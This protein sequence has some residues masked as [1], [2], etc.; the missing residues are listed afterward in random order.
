[1]NT[2]HGNAV[3]V[4]SRRQVAAIVALKRARR[5][6]VFIALRLTVATASAATV[7]SEQPIRFDG[8]ELFYE[9][10][11]AKILRG[12]PNDHEERIMHCGVPRGVRIYECVPRV[13]HA[14]T[15]VVDAGWATVGTANLDYRSLI[16][17][18][19]LN[20]IDEGGEL[21]SVLAQIFL[22]DLREAEEVLAMPWSQRS[23]P[24]RVAEAVGWWTRRWL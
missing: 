10:I 19:E 17:N 14:K 22:D 11:P 8:V 1:M 9:L 12:H 7:N 13:L 24:R 2:S 4:D 21:K 6:T 23:W 5:L 15:M 20:L 3:L 18:D 16:V